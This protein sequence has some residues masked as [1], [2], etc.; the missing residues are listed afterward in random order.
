MRRW[1]NGS[2]TK[3]EWLIWTSHLGDHAGY[4]EPSFDSPMDAIYWLMES[5]Q[6]KGSYS[7]DLHVGPECEDTLTASVHVEKDGEDVSLA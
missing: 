1:V 3:V 5:G 4:L 7:I 6:P 2:E